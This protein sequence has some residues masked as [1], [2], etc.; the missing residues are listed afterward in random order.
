MPED[1]YKTIIV[2]GGAGFI[3]SNYLNKYVPLHPE[4]L[5]VNIDS[6]TYAGNL[7][8]IEV[9]DCNN[10]A[11]EKVDICDYSLID[12]VFKKYKPDAIIHFAA[13]SHVD[14]SIEDPSIFVK[15]NILGTHNLLTL[16]K[17]N[18]V[19]RFHYISTDEVYG[20]LSLNE[21]PWTEEYSLDPRSP[22]SAS[23]ASG[24][25]L[26]HSYGE[27]FGL[28]TVITRSSNNYGPY[29]DK[30]KLIPLFI[31]KLLKDEKVPIYGKGE[32]VRD[33]LYVEDNCDA[34][35]LVFRKGKKGETYNIG[36][37]NELSN[38]ELTKK[39]LDITGKNEDLIENVSDRPGHDLRYAIDI[40]KIKGE[41]GWEP[42]TSFEEG[43]NKTVAYYKKIS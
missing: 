28:N 17:E 20:S 41:L 11:F 9:S 34:V 1:S 8:N 42:K 27:T 12:D 43:L 14:R 32:N 33:W 2:T 22:Y 16:S 18:N 31:T 38:I 5:F 6:L 26:T 40:T 30:S 4:T 36:G 37:G 3:G 15:T 24:E 25:L 23:K 10:Y 7:S 29:Q 19:K 21:N 13:E 35:E 39:L